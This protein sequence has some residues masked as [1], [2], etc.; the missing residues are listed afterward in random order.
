MSK[1]I[2][3]FF[4]VSFSALLATGCE[5]AM[6]SGN[7]LICNSGSC[8]SSCNDV[9]TSEPCGVQCEPGST[10]DATC[11]PGQN[12]NF[13]C[14]GDAQCDFD[15]TQGGCQAT[16]GTTCSC[17][18]DCTGT[19]GGGGPMMGG[20]AGMSGSCTDM[21]GNPLDPGYADCVAACG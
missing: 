6:R 20:D 19:C 21:C 3:V 4:L 10:C 15:C 18:G 5:D 12:C 16:G 7:Q 8:S 14:V 13:M 2:L 1:S 17:Q 11:N 9:D